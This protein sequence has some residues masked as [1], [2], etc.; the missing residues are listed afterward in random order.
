[1][2]EEFDR[3]TGYWW[4]PLT[5]HLP[6][7]TAPA[8][9][10]AVPSVTNSATTYRIFY[11]EVDETSVPVV[12]IPRQQLGGGL[13]DYRYPHVGEANV[14]S[15]A[16]LVEFSAATGDVCVGPL[17]Q[18]SISSLSLSLPLYRS[19]SLSLLSLSVAHLSFRSV[20]LRLSSYS[21]SSLFFYYLL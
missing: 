2:Q 21:P 18:S 19:L 7:T 5:N 8:A 3:Y 9:A 13:D 6:T 10:T 15:T 11:L 4:A 12:H 1:M 20:N 14:E 17:L 16:C